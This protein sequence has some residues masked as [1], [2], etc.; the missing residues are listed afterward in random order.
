MKFLVALLLFCVSVAISAAETGKMLRIPTRGD[1][2]VPTYWAPQLNAAATVVLL[3]GGG[4]GIGALNE[5]GWPGSSNFLIRSGA[6]FADQGFNVA[7]VARPSD[8]KDLDY[9]VRISESH[10][11]DLRA[12]LLKLKQM[13]SAPIWII[14][15]SRG[16]VSATAFAVSEKSRG[17]IDGVVL[18]SSVTN[19]KFTGAVPSQDLE[20]IGVPVLVLHHDKDA[21]SACRPYEV[22]L[23][24]KKLSNTPIKKQMI[25]DG[26]SGATGD[27]CEPAHWHG[28]IGM[29]KEVV[30]L[31]AD[32]I[33]RPMP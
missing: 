6:L 21:C 25:V 12:V 31:I 30:T 14:G 32:W 26:G 10:M 28:F 33:R 11:D 15:T 27:P 7:M 5:T 13:S 16:T 18:T 23:I 20:K 19:F 1:A 22:P 29:E 17:L 2:V 24:I 3:P 9:Q 8:I 4:G